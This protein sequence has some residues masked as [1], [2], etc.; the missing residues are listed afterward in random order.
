MNM[1]Q[2]S[3]VTYPSQI[4]SSNISMLPYFQIILLFPKNSNPCVP[5][6]ITSEVSVYGCYIELDSTRLDRCLNI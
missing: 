3:K 4:K 6:P 2:K 5:V 1:S